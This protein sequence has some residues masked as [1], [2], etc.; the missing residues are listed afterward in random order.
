MRSGAADAARPRFLA[1]R[2]RWRCSLSATGPWAPARTRPDTSTGKSSL[3]S[4]CRS[5]VVQMFALS[6]NAIDGFHSGGALLSALGPVPAHRGGQYLV[7]LGGLG[8]DVVP[9]RRR[10][11]D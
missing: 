9:Y 7:A 6:R 4:G 10:P 3:I 1:M 8:P 5:P 2:S 11:A